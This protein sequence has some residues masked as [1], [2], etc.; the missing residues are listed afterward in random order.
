[1]TPENRS[2]SGF[3][4]LK[5]H[6]ATPASLE[7]REKRFVGGQRA[8]GVVEHGDV[9]AARRGLRQQRAQLAIADGGFLEDEA[10]DEH[11]VARLLDGREHRLVGA[12]AVDEQLHLVA[13]DQRRRADVPHRGEVIVEQRGVAGGR[14]LAR[15]AHAFGAAD[16]AVGAFDIDG[17]ARTRQR[18]RARELHFGKD[19][20]AGECGAEGAERNAS[21][22]AHRRRGRWT[23]GPVVA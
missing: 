6:S 10:L 12:R 22:P 15:D 3:S 13:G 23:D 1:M 9:H 16:H 20:A 11:V 18:Q 4:G 19:V 8:H 5:A 7:A 2:S 17:R 21:H 14:E